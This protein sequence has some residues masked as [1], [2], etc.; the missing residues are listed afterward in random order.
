MKIEL[1]D[2]NSKEFTDIIKVSP[3]NIIIFNN[4]ADYY[5]YRVGSKITSICGVLNYKNKHKIISCFTLP[6][7]R[8]NG[9]MKEIIGYVLNIYKYNELITHANE[10]SYRIFKALGFRE[11]SFTKYKNF[12]RRVMI[13]N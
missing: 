12:T 3:K 9:Y 2:F 13:K 10:S 11:I 6:E 8:K 5:C 1:I 7:Y 4:K